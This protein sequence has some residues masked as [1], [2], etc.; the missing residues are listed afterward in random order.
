VDERAVSRLIME[1]EDARRSRDYR[2]ADALRDNLSREFSVT[3]DDEERQWWVGERKGN[4]IR[5]FN[6]KRGDA[7]P[8]GTWGAN[9]QDDAREGPSGGRE[10][11]GQ[12]RGGGYRTSDMSGGRDD[13]SGED[14]GWD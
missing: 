8:P 12:F 6:E 7:P 13:M 1:R 3:V 10:S 5:K 9:R 11:W 14:L 2:T 4:R